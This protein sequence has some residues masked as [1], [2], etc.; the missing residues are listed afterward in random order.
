MPNLVGV[1]ELGQ[2]IAEPSQLRL[3]DL[4]RAD[5]KRAEVDPKTG[6]RQDGIIFHDND[7]TESIID[8]RY[9]YESNYLKYHHLHAYGQLTKKTTSSFKSK[10]FVD[11]MVSVNFIGREITIES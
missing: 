8:G 4:R 1:D 11:R 6:R 3:K 9:T 10:Q 5:G 2:S 7:R